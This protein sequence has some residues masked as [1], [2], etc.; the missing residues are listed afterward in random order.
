M[1]A[2]LAAGEVLEVGQGVHVLVPTV[3]NPAAQIV[4]VPP[5]APVYPALQTQAVITELAAGE[6]LEEGQGVHV[7][8]P[9]VYD[10]A[11]HIVHVPPLAPV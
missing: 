4:Q 2:E 5:L 9:I 10:P 11:V 3:Y 1:I 8:V 6:V 7:L